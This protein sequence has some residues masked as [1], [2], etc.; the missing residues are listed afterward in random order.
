M[1]MLGVLV[2]IGALVGYSLIITGA[3]L[4][5]DTIAL[6]SAGCMCV[7]LIL[8]AFHRLGWRRSG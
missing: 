8:F 5:S 4:N 2:V 3:I 6:A 7:S 1:I